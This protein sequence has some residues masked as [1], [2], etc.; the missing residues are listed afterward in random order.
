MTIRNDMTL[1]SIEANAGLK[2]ALAMERSGVIGAIRESGMKGRGGAGFPTGV[3]WN[4]AAA[5]QGERKYVICNADEGEPGTFKDRVILSE[6]PDLVFEGMTIAGYAIG[7]AEGILYLRGEYTY[8]LK[9]LENCLKK[10]REAGLLGNNILGKNGFSFDIHIHMG[11]G[12]Y[13]CGEETALIESLE[14]HRGEAPAIGPRS[15]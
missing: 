1:A 8:L 2:A 14:G 13:V 5:A 7:A 4:L 10:R 12:A 6:W 15:R 9:G 11:S 3:K